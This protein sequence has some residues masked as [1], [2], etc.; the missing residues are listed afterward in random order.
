MADIF[1]IPASPPLL[2]SF[3]IKYNLLTVRCKVA[4]KQRW[5]REI[6]SLSSEEG[7]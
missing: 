3:H 5:G 2:P 4:G 1:F 6:F 7:K